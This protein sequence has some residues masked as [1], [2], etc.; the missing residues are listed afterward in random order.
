MLEV[1]VEDVVEGL[2]RQAQLRVGLADELAD[3][4][5]RRELPDLV[6]LELLQLVLVELLQ[7][8]VV[9]LPV[10]D[11]GL[12]GLVENVALEA[13]AGGSESVVAGDHH[14]GDLRFSQLHQRRLGL[15]L[16]SVL[17][18][19]EAVKHNVL[20]E[21]E[22]LEFD[23]L[24][25]DESVADGEDSEPHASVF[26]EHLVVVLWHCRR[27]VN[28]GHDLRRSLNVEI[29][30]IFCCGSSGKSTHPK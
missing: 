19:L 28:I 14:E 15:G 12:L 27:V 17:E 25:L 5:D 9:S 21:F 8:V 23:F 13:D 22:S 4:A 6:L 24:L 30:V 10:T 29:V 20:F 16:E 1:V 18:D 7:H 2:A 3:F 11:V 26:L